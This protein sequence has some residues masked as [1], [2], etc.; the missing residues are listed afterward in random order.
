M[1]QGAENQ[2]RRVQNIGH[3]MKNINYFGPLC[4][5]ITNCFPQQSQSLFINIIHVK[6]NN[7]QDT[8]KKVSSRRKID[9]KP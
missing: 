3:N 4:D 2:S 1:Q 7:T 5:Q 6:Q 9:N 8:Q